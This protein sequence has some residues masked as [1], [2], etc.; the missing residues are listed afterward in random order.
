MHGSTHSVPCAW[1][2]R[3]EK[4]DAASSLHKQIR[5]PVPWAAINTPE[6]Q[7]FRLTMSY[8]LAQG[9]VSY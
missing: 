2:T 6:V 3:L 4:E 9:R 7:D 1:E 8:T 5:V